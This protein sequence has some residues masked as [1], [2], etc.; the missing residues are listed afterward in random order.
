MQVPEGQV[1]ISSSPESLACV[2]VKDPDARDALRPNPQRSH[3]PSHQ[4][5]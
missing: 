1:T 2:E 3:S 4:Q 5:P